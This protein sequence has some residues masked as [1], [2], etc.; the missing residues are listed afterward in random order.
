MTLAALWYESAAVSAECWMTSNREGTHGVEGLCE[1]W[2]LSQSVPSLVAP[3]VRESLSG[4]L[5][6][7]Q[8]RR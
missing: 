8:L 1:W 4:R 6:S 5:R 7:R 3:D 2:V